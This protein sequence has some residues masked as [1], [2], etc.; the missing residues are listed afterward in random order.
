M[1]TLINRDQQGKLRSATIHWDDGAISVY[2]PNED[3][4]VL[5]GI[6]NEIEFEQ[7]G[8]KH[9]HDCMKEIGIEPRLN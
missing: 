7:N 3:Q 4:W 8:T 6:R 2:W 5:Q 1:E 9:Y